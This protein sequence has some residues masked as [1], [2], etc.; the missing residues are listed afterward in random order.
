M[1]TLEETIRRE[2]YPGLGTKHPP[3]VI[4]YTGWDARIGDDV[5]DLFTSLFAMWTITWFT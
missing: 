3:E 5:D 2:F 4:F 1:V